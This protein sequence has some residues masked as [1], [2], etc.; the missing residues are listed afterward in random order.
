MKRNHLQPELHLI[1]YSSLETICWHREMFCVKGQALADQKRNF[2]IFVDKGKSVLGNW[3]KNLHLW[4]NLCCPGISLFFARNKQEPLTNFPL[5]P[6]KWMMAQLFSHYKR[7][8]SSLSL[9][10]IAKV[11]LTLVIEPPCVIWR[12]TKTTPGDA[13]ILLS[14]SQHLN[15]SMMFMSFLMNGKQEIWIIIAYVLFSEIFIQ[16]N[17]HPCLLSPGSHFVILQLL[18]LVS[19]TY[20]VQVMLEHSVMLW[21]T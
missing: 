20:W 10:P 21:E 15:L 14:T 19:S 9:Q 2:R 8:V 17:F 7:T 3:Q 18:W 1:P 13:L 12:N 6:G 11:Q 5:F 4:N 16:G